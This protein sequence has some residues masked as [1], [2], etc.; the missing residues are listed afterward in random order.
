[1]RYEQVPDLLSQ[2]APLLKEAPQTDK[3]KQLAQDV[4]E[5]RQRIERKDYI[6][7]YRYTC[8]Q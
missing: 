3:I 2:A 8:G 5:I 7:G 6:G 1:M 4:E